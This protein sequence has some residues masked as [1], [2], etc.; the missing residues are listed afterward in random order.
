METTF[1]ATSRTASKGR[2]ITGYIITTIS[3]LFLLFDAI[4]KITYNH[5][6]VESSQHIG[7]PVNT[8]VPLG[9]VLLLCTIL[10][11]IPRTATLGAV[12]LTAWLGGAT[13]EN[14]RVSPSFIWLPIV[15]GLLVWLGL[16]LRD[17]KLSSHLPLR[18]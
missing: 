14:V 7:W 16:W 15:F 6:A 13:A 12:L 1:A 5:Y 9:W 11:V 18:K 17:S 8:L 10:Y 4:V 2:R 3:V